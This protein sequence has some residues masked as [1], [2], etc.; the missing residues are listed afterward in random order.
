MSRP[1]ALVTGGTRGLGLACSRFLASAGWD[2]AT[3]DLSELA[4][5]VYGEVDCLDDVLAD[6]EGRGARTCFYPADLTQESQALDLVEAVERDLGPIVGLVTLAGGDIRG[7]DERAAGGK[8]PNN[9]A[10]VAWDDFHAIFERNLFTC[11]TICR[12]VAP[13]M[14]ERGEGRI[15]TVSS[16]LGAIG[17]ARETSYAVAKAGVIHFSRCLAVELRPA[18]INVNCV[19]P[20]ATNTGRFRATLKD[21]GGFDLERLKGKG[22]LERIA[23]PD[24]ICSVIHFL[25][26]PAAGFVSGQTIRIDGG[27]S[28]SPV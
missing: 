4:C 15:V 11:V 14:A 12:A 17:S 20:G 25:L 27:H 5:S 3:T 21:R 16:V 10:F 28:P 2:V 18:G 1:L 22:R 13:R 24:D 8:A 19:A 6:L 9:T 7:N 26:S 23:E